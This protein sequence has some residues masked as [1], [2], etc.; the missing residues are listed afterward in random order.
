M[1]NKNFFHFFFDVH[2]NMTYNKNMEPL[3]ANLFKIRRKDYGK[4]C[5]H[6][7]ADWGS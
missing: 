2:A 7:R 4:K 3:M 1:E 5:K 6:R